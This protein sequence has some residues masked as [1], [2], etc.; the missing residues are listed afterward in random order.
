MSTDLPDHDGH[1]GA[2]RE[3]AVT[4][5]HHGQD[6]DRDTLTTGQAQRALDDSAAQHLPGM[7]QNNADQVEKVAGILVQT[8]ADLVTTGSTDA[9]RLLEERLTQAGIDLPAATIDELHT[10][11]AEGDASAAGDRS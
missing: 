1:N 11:I 8:H 3:D 9:R 2:S 10:Q 7:D 6:G 4:E 5:D